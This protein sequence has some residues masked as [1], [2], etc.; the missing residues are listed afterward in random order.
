MDIS[1]GSH[2]KF[3]VSLI[4]LAPGRGHGLHVSYWPQSRVGWYRDCRGRFLNVSHWREPRSRARTH[5]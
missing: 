3:W 2:A 1:T 5:P 4:N